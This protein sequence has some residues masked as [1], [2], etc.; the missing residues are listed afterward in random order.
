MSGSLTASIKAIGARP[1]KSESPRLSSLGRIVKAWRP[2]RLVGLVWTGLLGGGH[3]R[4]LA[5]PTA[6]QRR[7]SRWMKRTAHRQLRRTEAAHIE[8]QLRD[9]ALQLAAEAAPFVEQQPAVATFHASGIPKA[10]FRAVRGR[11]VA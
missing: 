4:D 3:T 11:A 10:W 6:R 2:P 5:V 9:S 7:V 8:E 1:R